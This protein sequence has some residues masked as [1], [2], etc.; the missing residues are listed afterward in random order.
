MPIFGHLPGETAG[1][2]ALPT[3]KFRPI[4][5]YLSP[6]LAMGSANGWRYSYLAS[7]R[8]G[9]GHI[10][11]EGGGIAARDQGSAFIAAYASFT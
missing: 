1:S 6:D 4:Q 7:R 2:L 11:P 9:G 5:R 10:T 3:P 8:D